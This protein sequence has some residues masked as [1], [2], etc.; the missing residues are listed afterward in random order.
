MSAG[1]ERWLRPGT[2]SLPQRRLPV[3]EALLPTDCPLPPAAVVALAL[4]LLLELLVSLLR[5]SQTSPALMTS[6]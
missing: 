5:L 3:V 2:F 1:T 6:V 4:P